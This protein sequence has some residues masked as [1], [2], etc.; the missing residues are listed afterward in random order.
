LVRAAGVA[1]SIEMIC[2][3]APGVRKVGFQLQGAP[4]RCQCLA[5]AACLTEGNAEFQLRGCRA[6]LFPA[7]RFQNFHRPVRMTGEALRCAQN[8][9]RMR[10]AR[11]GLEDLTRL[12]SGERGVPLEQ[13]GSMPQR[14]IQCSYGLRSAVQ[15]NIQSIPAHC[16]RLLRVPRSSFVKSTTNCGRR[17]DAAES[18]VGKRVSAHSLPATVLVIR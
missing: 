2:E 9:A 10:M 1:C 12:L 5:R 17:V 11:N 6:W 4:Q 8:Q 15:L 18:V 16:L 14:N 7:E 3:Q 13:S